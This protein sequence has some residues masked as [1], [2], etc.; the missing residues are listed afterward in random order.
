M[1]VTRD[2]YLKLNPYLDLLQGVRTALSVNEGIIK[3]VG[4][5]GSGKS[6]L[7]RKLEADLIAEDADVIYFESAPET[8]DE[9]YERIQN[10]LGLDKNKSFNK[11]LA[12]Y[13]Q[14]KSA[15]NNKLI[16]IYDDA[17]NISKELFILIRLLNNIHGHSETLVA[18]IICGTEKLDTLFDDP[19]LRSLTQYLNQSFV[20]PAMDR[21]QVQD[22]YLNYKNEMALS[23]KELS[24]T[25]L[26]DIFILGKGMPGKTLELLNE[27]LLSEAPGV[28][29]ES[30]PSLDAAIAVKSAVKTNNE[31]TDAPPLQ[32]KQETSSIDQK[33]NLEQEITEL[34]GQG[35]ER[36]QPGISQATY[37]KAGISFV[38]VV[39][40]IILAIILPAN[41]EPT[42]NR[43]AEI[44]SDDSPLYMDEVASTDTNDSENVN[45][46]LP[47]VAAFDVT[48]N[49]TPNDALIEATTR[50]LTE[51][52]PILAGA[53]T[54]SDLP[55]AVTNESIDPHNI[56]L[57]DI[58]QVAEN[59]SEIIEEELGDA[60]EES[61]DEQI[62]DQI[63][64]PT[65]NPIETV[66]AIQESETVI[67]RQTEDVLPEG[68][69]ETDLHETLNTWLLAWENGNFSDYFST[70]HE[71][72]IPSHLDS[73]EIWLNQ[74]RARI[75]GVQGINTDYD[76]FELLESTAENATARLWLAYSRLGYS[77]ETWKEIKFQK[78]NDAWLIISE[79]NLRVIQFNN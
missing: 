17:E 2:L 1:E 6:S 51:T 44:L 37:F 13:L 31:S 34:I 65:E 38:V 7:C 79:R 5:N 54:D 68:N 47:E 3:I 53:T 19:D 28:R 69:I 12:D 41:E 40:T 49:E 42:N 75:E 43:L 77:D 26:T 30:D 50:I 36:R 70:Y 29:T 8:P 46:S 63:T 14:A 66:V 22:F 60:A 25:E 61:L 32:N 57:P 67:S 18:Q 24:N 9:L 59:P 10:L 78:V 56:T 48:E 76:R 74:R 45:E 15:P 11:C 72:F 23:G 62:A 4:A 21:E 55:G 52:A 58:A 27:A 71:D 73:Y 35:N 64:E 39:V 16:V 33:E 20:I